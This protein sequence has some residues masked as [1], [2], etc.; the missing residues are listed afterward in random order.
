MRIPAFI[1]LWGVVIAVPPAP[2]T[3]WFEQRNFTVTIPLWVP[4][5]RG[6]FA[7]GDVGV[8]AEPS[9][10]AG[11]DDLFKSKTTIQ[12][13]F[14]GAIEFRQDRLMAH[15]DLFGSKLT[16]SLIFTLTD[17]TLISGEVNPIIPRIYAGFQVAGVERESA[18]PP[19]LEVWV[20]GGIRYYDIELKIDLLDGRG[21]QDWSVVWA[22]PIVGVRLPVQASRRWSFIASAD[23]GGFGI[24]SKY[25]WQVEG[26][27]IFRLS[28]LI[29]FRLGYIALATDYEGTVDGDSY[30]L[31]A[32]LAGPEAGIGFAF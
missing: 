9:P 5:F 2:A 7:K 20:Y 10:T 27:A 29:S 6:E 14:M 26:L 19:W 8:D 21:Q 31:R 11:I 22:D 18:A 28:N 1:L 23:I 15:A 30:Q 16:K 24:G 12:F 25:A 3:E 13:Y 17:G 32:A 4:S